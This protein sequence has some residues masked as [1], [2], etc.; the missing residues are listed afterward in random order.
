M[1]EALANEALKVF[2]NHKT[3]FGFTLE[4]TQKC[5]T[6][7]HFQPFWPVSTR[8]HQNFGKVLYISLRKIKIFSVIGGFFK[9]SSLV[10]AEGANSKYYKFA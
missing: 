6:S 5:L 4:C 7:I 8:P 1:A 9:A 2:P 3:D 10:S